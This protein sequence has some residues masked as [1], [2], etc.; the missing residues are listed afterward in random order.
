MASLTTRPFKVTFPAVSWLAATGAFAPAV[1]NGAYESLDDLVGHVAEL[2]T[3]ISR[4]TVDAGAR[5]LQFDTGVYSFFIDE[6]FKHA[7][8]RARRAPWITLWSWGCA[9]TPACSRRCPDDVTTGFHFCRGNFRSRWLLDGSIEPVAEAMFSVPFDRFLIEWED[10]ERQGD[11]SA[12]RH[13]PRGGPIVTLG[14]ISS[15]RSGLEEEDDI[16]RRIEAAARYVP[17]EQ[18]AVSP[19]CG[20]ASTSEG[21]E[22]T[23]PTTNG[24]SSSSSSAWRERV[25]SS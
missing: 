8:D 16:V 15:K 10:E 1:G 21:N 18:L 9:P 13:V 25:W 12:L 3:D 4:E 14:I 19:Q 6:H 11:F 23:P 5:Y 20:F 22:I 24:A 7:P 17:I 2:Q